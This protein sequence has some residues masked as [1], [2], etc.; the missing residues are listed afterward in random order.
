MTP[1]QRKARAGNAQ[2]LLQDGAMREAFEELE[3]AYL[4]D[5]RFSGTDDIAGRERTYQKLLALQALQ[6]Q[7]YAF[8]T[9]GEMAA[10]R[11]RE[12]DL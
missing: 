7:L 9:D 2:R 12:R 11:A 6:E 5:W 1:E 8:I 4:N 10:K 3:K